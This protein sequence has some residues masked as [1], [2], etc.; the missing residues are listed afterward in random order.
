MKM[1]ENVLLHLEDAVNQVR[2]LFLKAAT[3]IEELKPG[4]KVPATQLAADLAQERGMTGPQLY[5]TLKFLFDNYPGVEVKRGAHGG[6]CRPLPKPVEEPK[7]AEE[8]LAIPAP[9]ADNGGAQ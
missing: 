5:P 6:I 1:N 9:S 2:A 8:P 7:V 4:E 3:R